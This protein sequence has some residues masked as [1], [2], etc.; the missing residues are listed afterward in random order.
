MP[1]GPTTSY[2]S[3]ARPPWRPPNGWGAS[4]PRWRQPNSDWDGFKNNQD[5]METVQHFRQVQKKLEAT[6]AKAKQVQTLQEDAVLKRFKDGVEAAV[7]ELGLET[8]KIK[9]LSNIAS[10]DE[11]FLESQHGLLQEIR[12]GPEEFQERDQAVAEL[13]RVL[14]GFPGDD[15]SEVDA[16]LASFEAA[17]AHFFGEVESCTEKLE[18]FIPLCHKFNV[19]CSDALTEVETLAEDLKAK[20]DTPLDLSALNA[21]HGYGQK[22]DELE[23][24]LDELKGLCKDLTTVSPAVKVKE[25]FA[26]VQEAFVGMK[27]LFEDFDAKLKKCR[28]SHQ[29]FEKLSNDLD[30]RLTAAEAGLERAAA[31]QTFEE[32]SCADRGPGRRQCLPL[33]LVVQPRPVG[34]LE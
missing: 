6:A 14:Q 5:L 11:D 32:K 26:C 29:A 16:I 12:Q 18:T 22:I 33:G 8:K 27:Q 10:F 24:E 34:R 21:V 13:Y 9:E 28:E 15:S 3:A 25:H 7:K 30:A 17:K 19:G 31:Q 20:R 1:R 2:W 4:R 23:V